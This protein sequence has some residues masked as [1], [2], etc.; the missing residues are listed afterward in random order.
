MKCFLLA[1]GLGERLRPLTETTP[2]CLLPIGGKPLIE[3]WLQHLQRHG[4]DE[5]LINT[6]WLHKKIDEFLKTWPD[7]RL[8]ISQFHEPT[9]LGS[10]GTL[11]A[12]RHWVNEGKP[13]FIIFGDNLT[14]VDL[15]K[16]LSFHNTHDMPFT[17][18]VFKTDRPNQC[19][20]AELSE[21]G[22]VV[23]FVEKPRNPTTNL[24]AAGVYVAE[25]TIFDYFPKQHS[26]NLSRPLDLGYHVIPRLVG[27]MKAYLIREVLIDIGT[28][29]S[30]QKAQ[31]AW[32]DALRERSR[33]RTTSAST[34]LLHPS[35]SET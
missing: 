19:G 2:K 22:T 17:L 5:V 12:N 21:D 28:P 34:R 26:N 23:R 4:V 8:R 31:Q 24:A 13:F 25:E 9:L 18:G 16:M 35:I 10:A 29:E 20:I 27:K 1:A 14:N 6:H 33:C 15:T 7:E 32:N 30:Y 3:I 11:L